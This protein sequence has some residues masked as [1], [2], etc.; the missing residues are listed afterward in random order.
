MPFITALQTSGEPFNGSL[1]G[2]EWNG[3]DFGKIIL[4]DRW[5][6]TGR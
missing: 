2:E 6:M 4:V 3:I 1:A 5:R